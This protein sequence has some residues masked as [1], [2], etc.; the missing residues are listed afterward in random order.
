MDVRLHNLLRINCNRLGQAR[1][2]AVDERR[3]PARRGGE[4]NNRPKEDARELQENNKE[5]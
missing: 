5:C 4:S 3:R 1:I 2:L